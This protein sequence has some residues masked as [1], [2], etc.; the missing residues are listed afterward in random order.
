MSKIF[1]AAL[2]LSA[3]SQ[4][5]DNA[6]GREYYDSLVQCAAF[7][8]IEAGLTRE[9]ENATASHLATANDYRADA[10][11]HAV[12]GNATTADADIETATTLYRKMLKEGDPKDMAKGWTALESACRELHGV[13]AVFAEKGKSGESR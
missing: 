3:P 11:K 4:A 6:L 12:N 13:K 1:L 8:T 7:H 9:G 2:L 5:N 10:R